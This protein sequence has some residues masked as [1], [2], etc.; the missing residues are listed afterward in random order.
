MRE[1]GADRDTLL[2]SAGELA[3]TR[4]A[5]VEQA[6][7]V[8][9]L[10]GRALALVRGKPEQAEPEAD[11]LPRRELGRERARVVLVGVAERP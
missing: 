6:D 4:V 5:P 10:V 9:Q 1:R 8:E 7:A 3:G 2:L 11:L